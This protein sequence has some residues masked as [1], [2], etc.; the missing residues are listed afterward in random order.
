MLLG[1]IFPYVISANVSIHPRC[2]LCTVGVECLV[3]FHFH[4]LFLAS[5]SE[6]VSA[7]F[8]TFVSSVVEV[9]LCA[10]SPIYFLIQRQGS[11]DPTPCGGYPGPPCWPSFQS[12][13]VKNARTIHRPHQNFESIKYLWGASHRDRAFRTIN[14]NKG[15]VRK[16][17][18][19]FL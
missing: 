6:I 2:T 1:L 19:C 14:L 3:G 5:L 8:V 16:S 13:L 4:W 10:R 12:L 17:C 18:V 9:P 11:G 15:T 7:W